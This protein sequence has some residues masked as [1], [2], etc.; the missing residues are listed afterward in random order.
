LA[1]RSH[2]LGHPGGLIAGSERVEHRPS[3]KTVVWGGQPRQHA[4]PLVIGRGALR[5]RQSTYV[6]FVGAGNGWVSH[7]VKLGEVE[8]GLNGRR[9]DPVL[10]PADA[11]IRT[12]NAIRRP[13]PRMS[14]ARPVAEQHEALAEVVE[15]VA[16]LRRC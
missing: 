12:K 4:D 3:M 13:V 11:S 15:V 5:N 6:Q 1:R 14:F 2:N 8:A 9:P 7:H 16:D 10:V